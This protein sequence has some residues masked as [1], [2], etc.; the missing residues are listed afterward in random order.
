MSC[1]GPHYNPNPT[2]EWSRTTH[3]LLF[4]YSAHDP[5]KII[6]SPLT[7][8]PISIAKLEQAL[9][10]LRKGNILQY[11]KNTNSTKSELYALKMR[12]NYTRTGTHATQGQTYTNSNTKKLYQEGAVYTAVSVK[13]P[14]SCINKFDINSETKYSMLTGG[15][16]VSGTRHNVCTGE[17]VHAP[18]AKQ[19]FIN[20]ASD[21]PG[22]PIFLCWNSKLK[23]WN[24]KSTYNMS[25]SGNKWPTNAKLATNK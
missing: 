12:N 23:P 9:A 22:K 7:G 4:D 5:N 21:V 25:N 19:C 17:I 13:P 6:E 18:P 11:K 15:S 8:K 2:R 14:D 20:S 3:R 24:P 10:V 1:N 16:L